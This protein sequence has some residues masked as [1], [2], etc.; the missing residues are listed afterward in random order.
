[1][2]RDK[3]IAD[4]RSAL[5]LTDPEIDRAILVTAKGS[6][7][8]GTCEWIKEELI[9]QRWLE[10]NIPL[11]W[12]CGGPGKGKTMLSVFLV[13]QLKQEQ[14]AMSYFCTSEDERRNKASAVLR[15]LLWQITGIHPD[16]AKHFLT[17]LGAGE[18]N[19]AERIEAS[20]SSPET[21][22]MTFI[23]ICCDPR[24]SKF[25]FVLDGLD[26][27]DLKSRDWLSS[28]ICDLRT[29]FDVQNICSPQII[30]VS[31]DVPCL[32]LCNR[33][34]LD[35]D[36]DGKIVKDVRSFIS[37]RVQKLW[38][39]GGFDERHRQRVEN[40]PLERSEGTF[41]WVGFAIVELLEKRTVLQV[42]QCLDELPA[43]L[44]A[45]YGR[46]LRHIALRDT[47]KILQ[48]LQWTTLSARP[49]SFSELATAMACKA[50]LPRSA[51]EVVRD[52]VTLCQPFLAIQSK[53][54]PR[55]RTSTADVPAE[56]KRTSAQ[57]NRIAS[58][59]QTV[60]LIHQ[61]ARDFMD[62]R[63][64]PSRFRF[65]REEVHFT[66]AWKCMDLIWSGANAGTKSP[67]LEYAIEHWPAHAR[68][69]SLLAK[70]LLRHPSGFFK[71]F[72][73][74]R[75]W[76]WHQKGD[77]GGYLGLPHIDDS[78]CLSA[79]T[80]FIPWIEKV[81]IGGWLWKPAVKYVDLGS[82][83][84]PLWYAAQQGHEAALQA[85]LEHG[86]TT[87]WYGG[88]VR[89]LPVIHLF[90]ESGNEMAARVCLDYGVNL[91]AV[92]NKQQTP[93]HLAAAGGH[94]AVLQLLLGAGADCEVQDSYQETA[95]MK[96]ARRGYS[97]VVRTLL[98]YGAE[99]SANNCDGAS[100]LMLAAEARHEHVMSTLLG[101][102][103]LFDGATSLC[104]A[105]SQ[106]D[107][108]EVM[109]K[110]DSGVPV[111]AKSFENMTALY[112]AA[113]EGHNAVVQALVA[114][115]ADI[116]AIAAACEL[117][118]GKKIMH[119]ITSRF[120]QDKRFGRFVQLCCG[121]GADINTVDN[122]G[123][124][125]LH[126]ALQRSAV[127]ALL[128]H[129]ADV[130]AVDGVGRTAL[131]SAVQCSA[132]QVLLDH[133]A[134]FDAADGVGATS[135]HTAASSGHYEVAKLLIDHGALVDARNSKGETPLNLLAKRHPSK[136]TATLL[137][138]HNAEVDAKDMDGQTPLHWA[139]FC[140]RVDI[141][142][143]LLDRGANVE[144]IDYKG[145]TP[146]LRV[147]YPF[148]EETA[149][150]L[151]DHNARIDAE[152]MYGMTLLHS[153]YWA[154]DF[155]RMLLDR[156]AQIDAE[157]MMGVTPLHMAARDSSERIVKL[158]LERGAEVNFHDHYGLTPLN[159]AYE[160]SRARIVQLLISRG[161]VEGR[162]L[163]VST[164][165]KH[166][167]R[168]LTANISPLIAPF[169]RLFQC[170]E[171]DWLMR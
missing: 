66:I 40:T 92:G 28:K 34:Q 156:G 108:A 126:A 115:G 75:S 68:R 120:G 59:G 146:L 90:A 58:Q 135:P 13:E 11:L 56:L 26:E 78:L 22:W 161:A 123:R 119:A 155:A 37:A 35:P 73:M 42:E 110:L 122:R 99:V 55:D 16:L 100:A 69:A 82:R 20:L 8:P 149:A 31:R 70:P 21:L 62:S 127:Q 118:G 171:E 114:R 9:Y 79:Y 97:T 107:E 74:V 91:M 134:K 49:L 144:A 166:C 160:A 4:C 103:A 121:L 124:P 154:E 2:A 153:A 102:G 5:F 112:C 45:L 93:L 27:C 94:D 60:N 131:H 17:H 53:A 29:V 15:S 106:G 87:I 143:V 30:I 61:S 23:A 77:Q 39:L 98:D 138:D 170:E 129:G 51:E 169:L 157:D 96:A 43:G 89:H 111:N 148:S 151:L 54:G 109:L 152:D 65:K 57:E 80:G 116:N 46:M 48:L 145:R 159:Y 33:L 139:V 130:N 128:G 81:L 36:H 105:A 19:A 95:L 71:K 117:A 25:A 83:E 85:L 113:R 86:A 63:D 50:M 7:V 44:P 137:L 24:V 133:G 67:L 104:L 88:D 14:P 125:A 167:C 1:V 140:N 76:W 47:E 38:A 147:D 18:F 158:L 12:I 162:C 32:R 84:T 10:G 165:T 64:V 101:R 6:R 141:A 52:L 164:R 132:A 3:A 163:G 142:K 136:S 150:L 72:S 41:L 168:L